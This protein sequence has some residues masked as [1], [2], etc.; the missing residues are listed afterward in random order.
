MK[1]PI[2]NLG[3]Q[4][5]NTDYAASLLDTN[6]VS[7]AQNARFESDGTSRGNIFK[8]GGPLTVAA[9]PRYLLSYRQQTG[10]GIYKSIICTLD[11]RTIAWTAN[12][13]HLT[14]SEVDVSVSGYTPIAQEST[15]T[16]CIMN[17]MVFLNRSDRVPWYLYT[18][19]D[20]FSYLPD[21]PAGWTCQSL[22][23]LGPALVAINVTK[24]GINYSNE[25]NTSDFSVFGS[26]P[27]T[28]IAGPS[29]SATENLLTDLSEPL[30]D[31]LNLRGSMILYSNHE[32]WIMTP[33]QD[34]LIYSF[35]P[36]FNSYGMINTNCGVSVNNNH[37]VFG[38]TDIWSHDG[39]KFKSIAMGTIRDAIFSNIE[40]TQRHQF[41]V[42]H[43]D[44]D[45]EIG[46][47]YVS[48][49]SR[50]H[51]P[52]LVDGS[53][54]GC[55]RSAVY[56]YSFDTWTFY[57]LPYVKYGA[58]GSTNASPSYD[59]YLGLGTTYS[60]MNLS[61][62]SISATGNLVTIM[63]N[64]DTPAIP[65]AMRAFVRPNNPYDSG[66]DDL[67]AN[68][69]MVVERLDLN[70]KQVTPETASYKVITSVYPEGTYATLV[71]TVDFYVGST[72]YAGVHPPV[73]QGPWTYDAQTHYKVD[74]TVPGR[75]ISYKIVY[76][77]LDDFS[78]TG[79]DLDVEPI[80]RR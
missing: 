78:I 23:S 51:Y 53:Y 27:A 64:E 5:V 45:K 69:P 56:N 59:Y 80:G 73:Y 31:G 18:L 46:F 37:Y 43:D 54:P 41:F 35:S 38:S 60:A 14:S 71:R 55:N 6:V 26:P 24:D 12:G 28:W 8:M 13:G 33:T 42:Y 36:L 44:H 3:Q 72:D 63:V 19:D 57:D 75:F 47:C 17:G 2:V 10:T 25:V 40:Y 77:G 4:G 58:S 67:D 11:G 66:I 29:N 79:F 68:A 39:L 22:R 62:D 32:T 16:S 76:S 34:D 50:V 21:W 20:N 65:A 1:Y 7:W 70:L 49:D 9:D 74:F 52:A 30:V 48:N 15:Y 61:Y